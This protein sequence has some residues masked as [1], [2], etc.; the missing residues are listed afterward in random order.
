[1]RHPDACYRRLR[2]TRPSGS[3]S[4]PNLVRRPALSDVNLQILDFKTLSWAG[5]FL[6][7]TM[8][9]CQASRTRAAS[10]VQA[11]ASHGPLA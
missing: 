6:F 4:V 3:G 11:M 9:S 10:L 1:M 8:P 7:K 2:F 5:A